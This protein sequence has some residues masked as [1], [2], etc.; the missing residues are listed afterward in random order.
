MDRPRNNQFLE[1]ERGSGMIGW[2]M[3]QLAMWLVGGFIVYSLV[4]NHQLF[5]GSGQENPAQPASVH[6]VASAQWSARAPSETGALVTNSLTLQARPDGYAWVDAAVNGVPMNMAF[7]TGA[8]YVSLTE[9]DAQRAGV[10][11]NLNYSIPIWTANGSNPGAPVVLREVRIGQLT[12][13]NVNAIVQR[14]LA[15]SLL[16]QT[17]LNRLQSF[18]MERGVLTLSWQ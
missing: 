6:P 10:S 9:A 18:H 5:S 17:F 7:D 12:I 16:G 2:A 14:N 11:G 3:K 4:V 8:S 1:P 15:H 13:E